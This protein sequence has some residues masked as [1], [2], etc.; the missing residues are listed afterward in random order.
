ML[1]SEPALESSELGFSLTSSA[2]LGDETGAIDN[3]GVPGIAPEAADPS[4]AASY[5]PKI[6]EV[7]SIGDIEICVILDPPLTVDLFKEH[8]DL[9]LTSDQ[10][11]FTGFSRL[12]DNRSKY[13]EG[14]INPPTLDSLFERYGDHAKNAAE[15]LELPAA[16]RARGLAIDAH[17]SL[18]RL[19]AF[20]RDYRGK[21][22]L[23]STSPLRLGI[24]KFEP[25]AVDCVEASLHV[26]SYVRCHSIFFAGFGGIDGSF[27]NSL[28]VESFKRI[29]A[30]R[31]ILKL[32]R[33]RLYFKYWP[34][35]TDQEI[36]QL[37]AELESVAGGESVGMRVP[38]PTVEEPIFRIS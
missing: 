35:N 3:A 33:L 24:T 37:A 16:Q 13:T 10:I 29:R 7:T 9:A 20:D 31:P 34:M 19:R 12:V 11:G 36:R 4:D 6:R 30:V 26:A 28:I 8:I 23:F 1:S 5:E 32:S 15:L 21:F 25:Y 27:S 14:F 18:V 2:A 17:C 38:P 22:L